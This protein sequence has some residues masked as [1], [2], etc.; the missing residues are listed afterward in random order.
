MK[1]IAIVGSGGAGLV[2]AYRLQDLCDVTVFEASTRA[3]GHI[4]AVAVPSP[5]NPKEKLWVDTGFIAWSPQ[6]YSNAYAL[7]QEL[8]LESVLSTYPVVE[9]DRRSGEA[10]SLAQFPHRCGKDFSKEVGRDLRRFVILLMKSGDRIEPVEEAI[11]LGDWLK[12]E[13]YHSDLVEH[14]ILPAMAAVWGF[15]IDEI[16]AMSAGAAT[17]LMRRTMFTDTGVE[18]RRIVPSTQRYLEELLAR[19]KAPIRLSSEVSGVQVLPNGVAITTAHGSEVFDSVILATQPFQSLR[20]LVSPT[21]AQK[22]LLGGMSYYAS[23]AIVHRDPS[24]LPPQPE[25][26]DAFIPTWL[27]EIEPGRRRCCATWNMSAYYSL[28]TPEPI[29]VTICALEDAAPGKLVAADK[30]YETIRNTHVSLTPHYR[31]ARMSIAE[32]EI[33]GRIHFAG[34]WLG[35][36]GSHECAI[37]SGIQA[38]E[39]LLRSTIEPVRDH[40]GELVRAVTQVEMPALET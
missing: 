28:K 7:F 9:W 21:P 31:K 25:L 1:K 30:I 11:S 16:L 36:V 37:T 6:V 40:A 15:Q 3:G 39:R 35:P 18:Y 12:R 23:A 10:H 4:H 19:I 38:A 2:A 29:L 14:L 8:G 17:A 24:L 22:S 26:R 32:M 5:A 27:P 13:N 20:M 33:P 34:S